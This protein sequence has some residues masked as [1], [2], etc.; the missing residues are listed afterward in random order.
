MLLIIIEKNK[1]VCVQMFVPKR[2]KVKILGACMNDF[3]D[4]LPF[5]WIVLKALAICSKEPTDLT[6]TVFILAIEGKTVWS[7]WRFIWIQKT[8]T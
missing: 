8:C 7:A 6:V 5:C 3:S 1:L 4:S 2:G